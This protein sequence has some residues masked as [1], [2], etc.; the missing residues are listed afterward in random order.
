MSWHRPP[1]SSYDVMRRR[2]LRETE[3]AL[4]VG[5]RFPDVQVRIPTVEVG[6]GEFSRRFADE[7]WQVTLGLRPME[8]V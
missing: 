3:I 5:L 6:K 2:I 4:L 8:C 1:L 7:F